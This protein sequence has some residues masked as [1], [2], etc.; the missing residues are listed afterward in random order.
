[1]PWI[2]VGILHDQSVRS[3]T[4]AS[5]WFDK[6][7]TDGCRS[8]EFRQM[9]WVYMCQ[10]EGGEFYD[11]MKWIHVKG[12]RATFVVIGSYCDVHVI[13]MYF[14]VRKSSLNPETQ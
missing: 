6:N 7:Q 14:L 12:R 3:T 2:I 9:V 8:D 10:T 1:M 11:M 13:L 5:E 4:R